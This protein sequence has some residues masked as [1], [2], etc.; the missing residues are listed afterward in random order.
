M[1]HV[2]IGV[3]GLTPAGAVEAIVEAA[4]VVRTKG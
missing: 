3:D 1:A 4:V 2:S